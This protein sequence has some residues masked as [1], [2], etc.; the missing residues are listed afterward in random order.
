MALKLEHSVKKG[1]SSM[2]CFKST[3]CWH[4]V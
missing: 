3:A 1:M 2:D 4:L